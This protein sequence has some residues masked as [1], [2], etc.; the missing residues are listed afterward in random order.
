[1]GINSADEERQKLMNIFKAFDVNG[2]G[3][4][5]FHEILQGY[6]HYYQGD[7][8]RA[9]VEAKRFFEKL[10]FNNNGTID[11][12]EFLITHLD[13]ATVINEDRLREVFNLFDIDKS[14]A[15]TVDEIKKLLGGG[16]AQDKGHSENL[17]SPDS[18]N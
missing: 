1:M 2:D 15:I 7:D 5:E 18:S 9:E 6:K 16:L 17:N 11:Y 3:Q 13:P 10:D 8:A 4:L 14:G 12:S